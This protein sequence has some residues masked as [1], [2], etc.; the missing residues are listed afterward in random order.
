[1]GNKMLSIGLL[2]AVAAITGFFILHNRSSASHI[3]NFSA[4]VE[5]GGAKN[6]IYAAAGHGNM[7]AA[8]GGTGSGMAELQEQ[9][10]AVSD[11][12]DYPQLQ[13]RIDAMQKRH[14]GRSFK[15]EQVVETMAQPEAWVRIEN[16]PEGLPLTPEQKFDGREYIRFNPLRIETLMPGDTLEIPVWQQGARYE[17]HVDST[18]T[19]PNGSVTWHGHLENFNEPH[20][21][22]ITVGNGLSLA[23]IETP[24][25]HYELQANGESGW[26][27]SSETLFKRNQNETDMVAPP[28]GEP[29]AGP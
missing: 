23:G 8:K 19:H 26:I 15:S 4:Q 21:V 16:P 28:A 11:N 20:R 10:A 5:P 29:E 12:P 24:G 2:A 6:A 3:P 17:M 1:M 7:S 14:P 9:Y 27:A 13:M 22:T 25:G 18:E